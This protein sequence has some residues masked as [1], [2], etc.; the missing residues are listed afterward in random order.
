L[1]YFK[2]KVDWK[3]YL[4]LLRRNEIS[5]HLEVIKMSTETENFLRGLQNLDRTAPQQQQQGSENSSIS[6]EEQQYYDELF[7]NVGTFKDED[8]KEVEFAEDP[9]SSDDS[10]AAAQR[11]FSNMALGWGD[12]LGIGVASVFGS[13][14]TGNNIRDVYRD[15]KEAYDLEQE[16][17]QEEHA[18][19]ALTADIL[20]GIASP[21]NYMAAPA[22][23][24]SLAP[25]G[26]AGTAVKFGGNVAR[27]AGEGALYG[28]GTA[29]EG[30]RLEG[31][32]S[33]AMFGA[34][35]YGLTRAALGAAGAGVRAFTSR[36][37]EQELVDEAGNFLP[38]TLAA[39]SEGGEGILKTIYRDV[40]APS[41][42]GKGGIKSQE[43]VVINRVQDIFESQKEFTHQ[44]QEGAK[45]AV[46]QVN[47]DLKVGVKQ[48]QRTLAQAEKAAKEETS[49]NITPL[50]D[51]LKGLVDGKTDALFAKATKQAEQV[52]ESQRWN[53]RNSAFMEAFPAGAKP[54]QIAKVMQAEDIGSRMQ[55]LDELWRDVGY[56]MIKG[57]KIRIPAGQFENNLMKAIQDDAVFTA[58]IQDVPAFQRQIKGILSGLETFT[59]KNKRIDGDLL[60]AMRSRIGTYAD[61]AG[62]PQMRRAYYAVQSTIDDLIKKQLTPK[63][64]AAFAAERGKWKSN[65]LLREA[66]ENTR[67]K[68]RGLFTEEDWLKSA[69]DNS[70]YDARYGTGPLVKEAT[71]LQDYLSATQ[72]SIARKA[73]KAAEIRAKSIEGTINRHNNQLKGRIN[74]LQ[75]Q[76]AKDEKRLRYDAAAAQ[77]IAE[78][79]SAI[80]AAQKETDDIQEKLKVLQKARSSGAPSWFHTLAAT[81]LISSY[82][83]AGI[84]P[85]AF[86][87]KKGAN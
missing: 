28:A 46:K 15:M 75:S 6:P 37:I 10:L 3:I 61:A 23:L 62:D 60:S 30:E 29:K 8:P 87:N 7:K 38:I 4:K 5:H 34:A 36:K 79:K 11:F 48:L 51:K 64:L 84:T 41:L 68:K 71:N 67:V 83:T 40:I 32:E 70:K 22:R 65:V 66:V 42:G 14:A 26:A 18:G 77:R 54:D 1:A 9:W 13:L 2:K 33:G 25:A 74:S 35:G 78:N 19:A 21:L 20:G 56:S 52:V 63:Q 17:F 73:A 57:K 24:A 50:A 76:I 39:K 59:D 44:L 53:F 47:D 86:S 80:K 85:T 55:L 45:I 16:R 69:A 82:V 12:E 58:N 81:S 43:D 31:A 72:K 49:K 27:A